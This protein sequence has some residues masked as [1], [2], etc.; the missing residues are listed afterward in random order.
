MIASKLGHV[1]IV[2]LLLLH[3]QIDVNHAEEE[4]TLAAIL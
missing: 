1:D 3:P 2:K 4:V